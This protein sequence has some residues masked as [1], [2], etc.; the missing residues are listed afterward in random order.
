MKFLE[1]LARFDLY[2]HIFSCFIR[3]K[4]FF[5]AYW[6]SF[7]SRLME[8]R[9]LLSYHSFGCLGLDLDL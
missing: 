3:I 9:I 7:K 8:A 2:P 1:F 4:D 6:K 5:D